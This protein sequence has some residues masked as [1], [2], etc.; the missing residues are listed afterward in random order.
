MNT[1]A[2]AVLLVSIALIL[3]NLP[4]VARKI[5]FVL[6]HPKKT[7]WWCCLE[8]LVYYGVFIGIGLAIEANVSRMQEKVWQFY[9]I[10]ALMFLVLAYPG[11]VWRFLRRSRNS[12][13]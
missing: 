13:A 10:T 1:V 12:T 11:F 5:F 6:A 4:F 2:A 7:I 9:A 3:A 8:L